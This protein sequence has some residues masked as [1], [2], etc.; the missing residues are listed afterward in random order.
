MLAAVGVILASQVVLIGLSS[1]FAG[2]AVLILMMFI[3]GDSKTFARSLQ[4]TPRLGL[5]DGQRKGALSA[6]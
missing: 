6:R 2:S 4:A 3:R 1:T 5:S